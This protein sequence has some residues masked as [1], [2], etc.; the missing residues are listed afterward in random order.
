[1]FNMTIKNESS[2]DTLL[3]VLITLEE[4]QDLL[5]KSRNP[6]LIGIIDNNRIL[7][8]YHSGAIFNDNV[9]KD[10]KHS[11]YEKVEV[12]EDMGNFIIKFHKVVDNSFSHYTP[13]EISF[14]N[15]EEL[16]KFLKERYLQNSW[17][18]EKKKK[19]RYFTND[20][21]S[22]IPDSWR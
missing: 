16:I 18:I 15:L 8:Q 20:G 2:S 4:I 19:G 22:D 1:M 21:I 7:F 14:N 12:S 17:M 11:H 13:K 5:K 9:G 3:Q 6:L 10:I